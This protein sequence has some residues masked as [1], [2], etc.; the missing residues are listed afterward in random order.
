MENKKDLKKA[1]QYIKKSKSFIMAWEGGVYIEGN[2]SSLLCLL[3]F[4][5]HRLKED[6]GFN[7]EEIKEAVNTGLMSKEEL[8]TEAL[9]I[10]KKIGKKSDN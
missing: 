6:G 5:V 1:I 4:V 3:S 9:R 8:R 2:T 7:P 10:L